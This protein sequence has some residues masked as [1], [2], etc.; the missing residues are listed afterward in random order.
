M[1]CST[2]PITEYTT[3]DL[4]YNYYISGKCMLK[5]DAGGCTDRTI[6]TLMKTESA[7]KSKNGDSKKDKCSW[8]NGSCRYE[9]CTD[10]SGSTHA[11]CQK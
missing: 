9:N 7:C 1:T 6:C 11:E 4:C 3:D 2:A 5:A 8:D 10:F